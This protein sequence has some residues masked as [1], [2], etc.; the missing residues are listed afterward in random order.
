MKDRLITAFERYECSPERRVRSDFDL[1]PGRAGHHIGSLRPAAVLVPIVLRPD[2]PTILLTRRSAAL[3][4]H[5]GQISFPGGRID[6]GDRDAVQAALRETEEETGIQ[7]D[8]VEV[9]GRLDQYRTVTQFSITPVV[10]A[11]HPGFDIKPEPGEVAEIFEVPL[12]F[13]LDRANHQR[14]KTEW[15]GETRH[16]YAMPFASYYIWGATAAMLVNLADVLIPEINFERCD[17]S[18]VRTG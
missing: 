6:P 13:I 3:K 18:V 17:Q 11:V 1:N 2:S 8:Y 16:F 12:S 4:Q 10:A 7:R 9:I 14:E 15:R 5:A